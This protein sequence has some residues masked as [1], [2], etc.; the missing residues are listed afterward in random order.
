MLQSAGNRL[1]RP[2]LTLAVLLYT[3][4]TAFQFMAHTSIKEMEGK[5]I[6]TQKP[7]GFSAEPSTF[8]EHARSNF[9]EQQ[10]PVTIKQEFS[11]C[12]LV[13]D[14]NAFLP[15]WIAY[16]SIAL[17][18]TSLIVAVDPDSLSSPRAIL[19]RFNGTLNWTLWHDEDYIKPPMPKK[20]CD[21][22]NPQRTRE[23]H[24]TRQHRFMSSCLREV[25]RAGGR[26]T[27]LVDSDEYVVIND[28]N[29]ETKDLQVSDGS[30]RYSTA[31]D[32]LHLI[33]EA[34]GKAHQPCLVLPRLFF[35]AM[36]TPGA[37]NA[38]RGVPKETM[39]AV[40]T[41][42]FRAHAKK[43]CFKHNGYPKTLVD[44]SRIRSFPN[45]VRNPHR[46]LPECLIGTF[47]PGSAAQWVAQFRV[48]HLVVHHYLGSWERYSGRNDS[49]RSREA[50]DAKAL[51]NKGNDDSITSWF[52]E[53]IDRIGPKRALDLL[54]VPG[55]TRDGLCS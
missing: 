24:C 13:K 23:C 32:H 21:I 1:V 36:E 35:S 10:F 27:A 52:D 51:V 44:V 45:M 48:H 40:S 11:G 17:P 9:T 55:C 15:E 46:P 22:A 34:K 38:T 37:T 53:L 41:L 26:W 18:L 14:D 4:F 31:L 12:L 20:S 3:V 16:H 50:F 49:R 5:I 47:Q 19:E 30:H 6:G 54:E 8:S 33:E 42:R 43:G 7:S 28:D 2:A 39:Q 25:K 29:V